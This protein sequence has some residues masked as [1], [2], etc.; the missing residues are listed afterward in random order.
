MV[1]DS[2][3]G[4]SEDAQQSE[5]NCQFLHGNQNSFMSVAQVM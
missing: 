1:L 2:A 3:G 4:A 5:Q